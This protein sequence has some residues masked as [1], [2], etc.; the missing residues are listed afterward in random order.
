VTIIQYYKH[1]DGFSEGFVKDFDG[2][3]DEYR[4]V[5]KIGVCDCDE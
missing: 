4:G 1:N 5:F 2:F 3:T